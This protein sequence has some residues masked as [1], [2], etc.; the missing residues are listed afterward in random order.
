MS[1][2]LT[3][4]LHCSAPVRR[5]A[6][7][8]FA[9]WQLPFVIVV[10]F[11]IAWMGTTW[12]RNLTT[13]QWISEA[14]VEIGAAL[15]C[16][17]VVAAI[18]TALWVAAGGARQSQ[19][20][21]HVR[22][23]AT[24]LAAAFLAGV[25]TVVTLN[26]FAQ[27]GVQI[28]L[29]V[30]TG[31]ILAVLTALSLKLFRAWQY[32]PNLDKTSSTSHQLTRR[33]LVGLVPFTLSAPVLSGVRWRGYGRPSP[34]QSVRRTGD[35]RP[36]ILLITFDALTAQDMWLYGYRLRTTPNLDRFARDALTFENCI[37][38]S[39]FTTSSVTSILTGKSVALH[40][41]FFNLVGRVRPALRRQNIAAALSEQG[42]ATGAIVTNPFAHPSHIGLD[43]AFDYLPPPPDLHIPGTKVMYHLTHSDLGLTFS[44][45]TDGRIR[46]LLLN[47][48]ISSYR[49]TFYPPRLGFA[50]ALD[51][52][53]VVP[54]PYFLWLHVLAPH[55]PYDPPAP[56]LGRYLP[57][58][59]YANL[60]SYNTSPLKTAEPGNGGYY[61]SNMQS[62]VDKI[63]L[64]YDEFIS[65]TDDAFGAF[66]REFDTC[67][68][69]N[70]TVTMITSDHGE[71]FAHGFWGHTI[72]SMWQPTIDIPL[73]L[74]FP[75]SGPGRRIAG[76]IGHVDIVP[77]L[78][79][80]AGLAPIAWS[81]GMSL[82]PKWEGRETGNRTR[83]AEL[84]ASPNNTP[85]VGGGVAIVNG[86]EKVVFD[87]DVA[88]CRMNDLVVDPGEVVDISGKFPEKI[89]T[90]RA[91][92][93]ARLKRVQTAYD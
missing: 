23:A 44:Q 60:M 63:R 2:W 54:K 75:G 22:G 20:S 1:S 47:S 35:A 6:F 83:V 12:I 4:A 17:A 87:L 65:Y 42:Y 62:E 37:S 64:R 91:R 92:L 52:I 28:P 76:T 41:R 66:V 71:L 58:H 27:I 8:A 67:P 9:E 38:A 56:F 24:A 19:L 25:L 82:R 50:E 16:A 93:A 51:F 43:D 84:F 57:G 39:N 10:M 53:K 68:E 59:E 34:H 77:T 11:H 26:W 30:R 33:A 90:L 18:L 85:P 29:L 72:K 69:A 5:Y 49:G 45:A 70:N 89:S 55:S 81:E 86:H 88:T 80:A 36:N 15:A 78:L 14:A 74:K 13:V 32:D 73:I 40:G 21:K 46:N 61:P 7:R 31:L 79:D 48:G 3:A